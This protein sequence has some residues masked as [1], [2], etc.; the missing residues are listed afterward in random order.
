ME[1]LTQYFSRRYPEQQF[2]Y[3]LPEGKEIRA[4]IE[5]LAHRD[6]VK[7]LV[8]PNKKKNVFARL[9]NPG[10]PHRVIFEADAPML[11]LPV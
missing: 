10:I 6:S 5:Q 4:S 8:V 3:S 1:A 9:F 11:A 7:M 2:V